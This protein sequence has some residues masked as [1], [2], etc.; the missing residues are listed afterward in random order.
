MEK[1][2]WKYSYHDS[3]WNIR[4]DILAKEEDLTYSQI[5]SVLELVI[6]NLKKERDY[7]K[8]I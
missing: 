5:I 1:D 7:V 3:T 4:V 6:N 2:E 8:K